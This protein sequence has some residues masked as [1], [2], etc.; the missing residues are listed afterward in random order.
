MNTL[1][2]F[3]FVSLS[4]AYQQCGQKATAASSESTLGI[5]SCV[6]ARIDEIKKQPRWNPPA[7]VEEYNYNGKRVFLFS[8]PC[9]DQYNIAVDDSCNQVC[10][11]SGGMTGK[12]D[13]KCLDF[14][15]KAKLV[16][17]VWQDERKN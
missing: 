13:R 1:L 14:G 12:G 2:L 7:K 4:V 17:V 5:P 3:A 6:Q 8:S 16:S 11:P 10:A 15:E 9:C